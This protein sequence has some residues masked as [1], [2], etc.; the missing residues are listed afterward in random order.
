MKRTTPGLYICGR[1]A[2]E[3]PFAVLASDINR[4]VLDNGMVV[5][6]KEVYPSNVVFLSLWARVGSTYEEDQEAGISHF[7][8]HMLFKNTKK[9]KVG[10]VAQEIHSLGGYLNGFTSYDC[11]A[12][13]MVLPGASLPKALEIQFDA[14]FNPLFDSREVE[15]ERNVIIEEIKMY[16]DRPGDYLSQKLMAA[17][18]KKHRYGRPIIGFEDVL[19]KIRA[20]DLRRYYANYYRPNNC[21]LLAVGDVNTLDIVRKCER[22]YR[23]LKDAKVNRN[24]PPKEPPQ[25]KFRRFEMEGETLTGHLQLAFH[26]PSIFDRD[27]YSLTILASVLGG[28]E[29]SRL[30]SQLREKRKLVTDIG[31]YAHSQREPS[32]LFIDAELPPENIK[33]AED[34]IFEIIDDVV[35]N[36]LTQREFERSKNLSE[37]GYVFGQETVE[38]QGRKI[39]FAEVMGDYMMVEKFIQ[40]LVITDKEETEKVAKKYLTEQ[41]CTMG[42]YRPTKE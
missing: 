41:N 34:A 14:I 29:S 16:K 10:Q 31:A 30:Y 42:I 18:F 9:R 15:K 27:I 17:A 24:Q 12:Y 33:K 37:A 39:G 8:E 3:A 19:K 7:V 5:L 28:G 20:E 26:I 36:G 4:Y 25:K 23:R 2:Q 40:R 13:W 21:F 11:T 32:L 35:Q 1:E 22:T 38:T 6:T